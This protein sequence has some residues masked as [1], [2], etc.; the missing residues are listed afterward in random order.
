MGTTMT[1]GNQELT[2]LVID[3]REA[4]AQGLAEL[5]ELS[6]FRSMYALTGTD[7]LSA[8]RTE[9]V[10]AILLDLNLPDMSGYDV[11]TALRAQPETKNIAVIFHTAE[12][13]MN[14]STQA[15]AFL[16]YPIATE[17]ICTVIRGCIA[18]RA[19]SES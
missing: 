1:P 18:K 2:V 14:Q 13:S 16:T 7:G 5:L 6:G 15:D 19:H 4:H 10:D 9:N 17:H 12:R 3:D 8:A 11:C